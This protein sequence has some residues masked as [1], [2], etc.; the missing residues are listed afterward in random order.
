MISNLFVN[1]KGTNKDSYMK[2]VCLI[3]KY[4]PFSEVLY[5]ENGNLINLKDFNKNI[6]KKYF[7]QNYKKNK[8]KIP[9]FVLS[10]ENIITGKIVNNIINTNETNNILG[11]NKY[12]ICNEKI[13]NIK[14]SDLNK[15]LINKFKIKILTEK[16]IIFNLD[17]PTNT[18]MFLM[19]IGVNYVKDYLLVK[20]LGDGFYLE[21]HDLPHYY[22]ALEDEPKGY[23][24]IGEKISNG[25]SF[26]AFKIPPKTGIYI[27]PFVY[28]SDAFLVGQYK[29]I[30]SNTPNYSTYLIVDKN[31]NPVQVNIIL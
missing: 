6:H 31:K 16:N 11:T 26:Y 7:I 22:W 15:N 17:N 5:K 10:F 9:L 24:I 4:K 27:P 1:R 20:D 25:F 2:T 19:D 3:E 12:F 28:H 21:T 23:F 13:I 30:Y 29:V 8:D 14:I 18:Y